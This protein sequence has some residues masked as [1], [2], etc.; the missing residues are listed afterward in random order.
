MNNRVILIGFVTPKQLDAE[1]NKWPDHITLVPYFYTS[2]L[3]YL[4]T[5]LQDVAKMRAPI[6]Y[7]VGELAY[8]GGERMLKV[9]KLTKTPNLQDLHDK[10]LAI[11]LA[12]DATL[13]VTFCGN[14]YQPHITHNQDIAPKEGDTNTLTAFYLVE[15][16]HQQ[17]KKIS[18][19]FN[20]EG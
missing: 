10:L 4:I 5:A 7:E 11:A 2:N 1:F 20:L 19:V 8:F 14:K 18:R 6:P 13:D 9:N 17:N 16:I 15:D 3:D 12:H